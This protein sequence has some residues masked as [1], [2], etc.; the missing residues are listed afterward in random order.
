VVL[1]VEQV[2]LL[3][4]QEILVLLILEAVVQVVTVAHQEVQEQV[5]MAVVV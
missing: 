3:V 1:E 4:L 2:L 5:V